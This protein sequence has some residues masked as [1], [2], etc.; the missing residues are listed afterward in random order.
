MLKRK[1]IIQDALSD[2]KNEIVN[3]FIDLCRGNDY[4][5]LNLLTIEDVINRIYDKHMKKT[6]FTDIVEV[7]K[8]AKMDGD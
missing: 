7:E 8:V 5:K 4:N 6:L 3:N 1:Y 2:F